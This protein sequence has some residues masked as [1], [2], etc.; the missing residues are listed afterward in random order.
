MLKK[1]VYWEIAFWPTTKGTAT[2]SWHTVKINS[3]KQL[4]VVQ[5]KKQL[6]TLESVFLTK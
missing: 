6:Q 2:N 1:G 5:F 4:P 3:E